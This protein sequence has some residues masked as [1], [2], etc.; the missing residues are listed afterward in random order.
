MNERHIKITQVGGQ[1]TLLDTWCIPETLAPNG[2]P[3]PVT[4]AE[5]R[6]H[7]ESKDRRLAEELKAKIEKGRKHESR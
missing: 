1:L 5:V 4:G 6:E 2:T 7:G 3:A